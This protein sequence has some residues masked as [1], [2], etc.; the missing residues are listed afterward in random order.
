M[1]RFALIISVCLALLSFRGFAQE[2]SFGDG[3]L[4][5]SGKVEYQQR[6]FFNKPAHDAQQRDSYSVSFQPEIFYEWQDGL[7]SL[8]FVPLVRYDLYDSRRTH[9]DIRELFYQISS[10]EWELRVGSRKVF[11]GVTESVH[12][13]DIINQTDLVESFD[14]EEKFGQP[15]INAAWIGDFGTLDI[16]VMP[17]FRERSFPGDKGRL[18]GPL[19]VD[20][21]EYESS[22]EEWHTDFALR[23]E[24]T[25]DDIDLGLSYF[26]GTSR[27]PYF[28][29]QLDK[30]ELALVAVYDI[31]HQAGLDIQYTNDA[32]LWKYEMIVNSGQRQTYAAHAGGFEYTFYDIEGSGLDVGLLV[33]F[34][35]DT[36]P[37][38]D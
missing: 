29:T 23:F 27:D 4:E 9:G 34:L 28:K 30:G 33:E 25:I 13:V 35:Y 17:Y 2:G 38:E 20:D 6:S 12:L 21:V 3:R 26:Y 10:D 11:W 7:Q 36:R 22:A 31:V 5:I 8:L 19:A 37:D 24:K 18:R 1:N 15:M 14:G 32:W 16:F